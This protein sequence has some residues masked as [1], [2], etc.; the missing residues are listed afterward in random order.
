MNFA[1]IL[2]NA[3]KGISLMRNAQPGRADM[4]TR[5]TLKTEACAYLDAFAAVKSWPKSYRDA[6]RKIEDSILNGYSA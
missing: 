3:E 4:E 5:K 2:A 6:V 1:Q